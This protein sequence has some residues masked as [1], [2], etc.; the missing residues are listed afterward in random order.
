MQGG[1]GAEAEASP[2][3]PRTVLL[4][5]EAGMVGSAEMA[6][7]I[8]A[9]DA[10][11]AKLVVVGDPQQLGAI[12][13]GGLYRALAERTEPIVLE[14]AIRHAHGVEREAAR[15]IR[16][17][18]GARALDLYRSDDR[19]TVAPDAEAR[20]AAM[21][22]D[23]HA[24][25]GEG[26]DALMVAK[27]NAEAERLN[28]IAREL[29]RAEGQLG[30]Q[31]IE[32]GEA[33]FAA[34]DL[35]IIRVNDHAN[36][37]Y[38]RERWE[39]AEVD[40]EQGTITLEGVEQERS[41]ELGPDYLE[42]TSAH[43]D[44]PALEHAY[45]VTTYCA[46]GATVDSAFVAADPS[47]DQQELYVA[48]SR[49]REETHIYASQEIAAERAEYAP[50]EP[51]VDAIA[52]IAA[53]AQR[54]RAQT[55]AHDEALQ[56]EL[57]ELSSE[58]LIARRK[59]LA[60]AAQ[61]EAQVAQLRATDQ[62]MVELFQQ[63]Y[64]NAV[65]QREAAEGLGWRERRRELPRA[66]E[67]EQSALAALQGRE[68][69]RERHGPL[70]EDARREREV[71]RQVLAERAEAPVLASQISPPS[72]VCEELGPRPGDPA[73]AR[74]WEEGVRAIETYRH[75]RGITDRSSALGRE[76]GSEAD[77]GA[78]DRAQDAVREAQRRLERTQQLDRTM[79]RSQEAGKDAGVDLGL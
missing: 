6:E 23:W 65:A 55:A 46:Q 31:E 68:E 18:Q 7:L 10:A 60:G 5:D 35:V 52:Q 45:A 14:E 40:A 29:L 44:G 47:M 57:R 30:Q 32:V 50:L 53:A 70:R 61:Q 59:A 3:S 54:D 72:Y 27:R 69:M 66:A 13:A 76:P 43:A 74:A 77:R 34:G 71:A 75:E 22:A 28:A 49:S 17:G 15:L 11:G 33:R 41:V 1:G 58:E 37:I 56:A 67:R 64:E 21:V 73:K 42:R 20:R 2:L 39:V 4:V 51:G 63:R 12:E 36:E 16:E 19:V 24:A 62:P 9:A 8:H 26:T 25:H 48:V 38:N 79:Q 78:R